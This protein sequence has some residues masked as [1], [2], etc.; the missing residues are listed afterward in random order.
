MIKIETIQ[1]TSDAFFWLKNGE[2]M[3]DPENEEEAFEILDKFKPCFEFISESIPVDGSD[4]VE[5][6]IS[7]GERHVI[8][9]T[10][11]VDFTPLPNKNVKVCV[12]DKSTATGIYERN[13]I[14]KLESIGDA[15]WVEYKYHNTSR[16]R[17]LLPV[18]KIDEYE[19]C[20][21]KS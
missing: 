15:Y 10:L 8:A 5:V 19:N 2:E 13:Q 14:Q 12:T 6:K 20:F 1:I 3:L 18:C 11:V 21:G 7:I 17:D 4:M 16:C 9:G